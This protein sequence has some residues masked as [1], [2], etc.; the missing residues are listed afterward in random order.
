MTEPNDKDIRRCLHCNKESIVIYSRPMGGME[1]CTLDCLHVCAY[2]R[3]EGDKMRDTSYGTD[4]L[5]PGCSKRFRTYI[6]GSYGKI[7]PECRTDF[8]IRNAKEAEEMLDILNGEDA[9]SKTSL[10]DLRKG[11]A[12][13]TSKPFVKMDAAKLAAVATAMK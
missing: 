3:T 1:L 5:C 9:A 10:K 2:N 11:Q 4:I 7:C 8:G 12:T 6:Q 13:N